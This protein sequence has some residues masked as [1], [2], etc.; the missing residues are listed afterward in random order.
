MSDIIYTPYTYLI[1][2][3]KHKL[4]YYGVR[5]AKSFHQK[6]LYESGCHPDELWKTYFTSSIRVSNLRKKYGEP[7]I[8][9]VRK[10]FTCASKAQLWEIKVLRRINAMT[11]D[12]WLNNSIPG[13]FNM[14]EEIK[15]K[16][17]NSNKKPKPADFGG[18][19]SS[20]RKGMKFTEAHRENIRNANIGKKQSAETKTKRRDSI[21]AL[22]WWNDG[23]SN[24]RTT[25]D[26]GDGWTRGRLKGFKW[27]AKRDCDVS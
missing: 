8:I 5:Y 9:Q 24:I 13:I 1:G 20:A 4:W 7:D 22:K 12:N 21:S 2:W 15:T 19:I 26:P 11:S 23:K 17:S 3:S 10:T 27:K 6:C 16:I 14:T 25:S 18:K